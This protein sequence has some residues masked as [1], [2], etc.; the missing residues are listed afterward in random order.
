MDAIKSAPADRLRME[1]TSGVA[2]CVILPAEGG[3]NFTYVTTS[4]VSPS[5]TARSPG[6]SFFPRIAQGSPLTATRPS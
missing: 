6:H 5:I 2:P 3:E 4:S 1:F